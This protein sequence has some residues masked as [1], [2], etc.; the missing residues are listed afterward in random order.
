MFLIW[1]IKLERISEDIAEFEAGKAEI[2]RGE[3]IDW[4]EL[5][6]ELNL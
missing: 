6:K 2:T 1:K 4:D 5:R 3:W